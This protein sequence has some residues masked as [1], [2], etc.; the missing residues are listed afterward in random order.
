MR[1]KKG[2][3]EPKH[4]PYGATHGKYW[5]GRCDGVLISSWYDKPIK[6]TERRKTKE[7]IKKELN[8][9]NEEE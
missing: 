5:C 9:E 4:L 7:Q 1:C 8:D 6:K 3:K 2:H